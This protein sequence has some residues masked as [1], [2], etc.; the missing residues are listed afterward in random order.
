[1]YCKVSLVSWG[2]LGKD[3]NLGSSIFYFAVLEHHLTEDCQIESSFFSFP[4]LRSL[5]RYAARFLSCQSNTSFD[6]MIFIDYFQHS[7]HTF[8]HSKIVFWLILSL[9]KAIISC[10]DVISAVFS[11]LYLL[12]RSLDG[13][14]IAVISRTLQLST[15][16]PVNLFVFILLV[17]SV[18]VQ[19]E[20]RWRQYQ[21]R[22]SVD[23]GENLCQ[24][25]LFIHLLLDSRCSTHTQEI[26]TQQTE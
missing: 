4:P 6:K 23:V 11:H 9:L 25:A 1:M 3:R 10:L 22:S 16:C 14:V 8:T 26:F 21:H 5:Y 15:C 20:F 2:K 19:T 7:I 12:I 24:L 13:L 18:A 17:L